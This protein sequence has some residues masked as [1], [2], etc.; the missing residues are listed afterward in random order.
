MKTKLIFVLTYI[1]LIFYPKGNFAQTPDLGLTSSFALFTATGA[2]SND[3]DATYVIGDVGT[4][5]GTF[6]AFPT[7]TVDGQIHVVDPTSS[8]AATDVN[9]AY[10]YL[11]GITCGVNISSELGNQTL[12]QNVYCLEGAPTTLNGDLILDG[13]GDPDALFIF[14]INGALS[15]SSFSNII[16]INSSNVNNIYWQINGAFE[17]GS[18]AIFKGT[19]LANGAISLLEN[20]S[21]DGQGLSCAGAISLHNNSVITERNENL[22]IKLI[23]FTA[24]NMGNYVKFEW[25]TACEINNNF[26]TIQQSSDGISFEKVLIVDGAGNSNLVLHY[27]A[28]DYNSNNEV[29]Y[30]R[31]KQ[32]DFD[33]K[34]SYSKLVS[35]DFKNKTYFK[36]Y[37]N[38]ICA[39]VTILMNDTSLFNNSELIICNAI[40]A[41]VSVVPITGSKTT[42]DT[43]FFLSG[44]Y[45][46]TLV[47]KKNIIK[48]G[49]MIS[50]Q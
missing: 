40:G 44:I 28:S 16:L 32:T 46:Y 41:I 38:P 49:K 42:S 3:G 11:N 29:S 39:S 18:G 50:L 2:F 1:F 15:V 7:G 24:Q 36:I 33:G 27:S 13:Q 35:V 10:S 48:T 37:P 14:Q 4:N 12:T 21:L 19:I 43:G 6:T 20:S 30:Y 31:L 23:S 34:F 22:P 26:F 17:L 8:Q 9:I 47:S 45:F 25:V 5:V